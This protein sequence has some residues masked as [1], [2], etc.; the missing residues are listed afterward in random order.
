M[1]KMDPIWLDRDQVDRDLRAVRYEELEYDPTSGSYRHEGKPFN[2][3]TAERCP[4]GKLACMSQYRDGVPNG[5]A[6]SWH[7]DG[8]IESYSELEHGARHGVFVQWDEQGNRV[9]EKQYRD[10]RLVR[11]E[12]GDGKSGKDSG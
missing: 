5:V 3:S 2:G 9:A 8:Q 10:G 6:A 11:G 7:P 12:A 1:K 4:D